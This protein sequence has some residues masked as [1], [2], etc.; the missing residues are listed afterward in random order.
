MNNKK[1]ILAI[2]GSLRKESYNKLLLKATKQLLP[3]NIEMEIFDLANIPMYNQDDENQLPI[4]VKEFKQKIE[5]ADI[6]LIAT[7]EYNYSIS[8][9][10]KNAMDWASRP[11]NQNSF[12]N[13]PLGILGASIGSLGTVRAQYSLREIAVALNMHVINRPEIMIGNAATKFNDHGELID[14]T[15]ISFINSMINGLVEMSEFYK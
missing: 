5:K 1:N 15:T 6:I 8:G 9:V 12:N 3:E 10:L 2:A 11:Y 13:K 4:I 14:T 7:P